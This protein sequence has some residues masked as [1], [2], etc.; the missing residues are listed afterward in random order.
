[1]LIENLGDTP[2]EIRAGD[3]IANL[4]PYPVLTANVSVVDELSHSKRK[5]GGFGSTGR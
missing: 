1:V 4:I 2:A 3:K 5:D